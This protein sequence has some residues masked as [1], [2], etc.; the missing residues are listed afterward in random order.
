MPT[1]FKAL[2]LFS[3]VEM[4][5]KDFCNLRKSG[6]IDS[7]MAYQRPLMAHWT[8]PQT[9][10]EFI[11][12]IIK[13]WYIQPIQT[14]AEFNPDGTIKS[15]QL[16]DGKQRTNAILKIY[17]NQYQPESDSLEEMGI[18]GDYSTWSENERLQ[19]EQYPLDI[20]ILNLDNEEDVIEYFGR[21]NKGG[22]PLTTAQ[23]KRGKYI[24]TLTESNALNLAMWKEKNPTTDKL[25]LRESYSEI[26][27]IQ[28]LELERETIPN[29]ASK[30]LIDRYISNIEK[31]S[32]RMETVRVK[33]ENMQSIVNLMKTDEEFLPAYKR[34]IK[35][36]HLATLI[37]CLPAEKMEEKQLDTAESRIMSFFAQTRTERTEQRKVY[38]EGARQ[39]TATSEAIATR[40]KIMREV[41]DGKNTYNQPSKESQVTQTPAE[42][43]PATVQKKAND[44]KLMQEEHAD[45]KKK[46]EESAKL[47]NMESKLPDG[48]MLPTAVAP[49]QRNPRKN[50]KSK[51]KAPTA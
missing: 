7:S 18:K 24:K 6:G 49:K 30:G 42:E 35:K 31:D 41:L 29:F 3:R 1:K 36:T 51:V 23:A 46:E 39:A 22:I 13:G 44:L 32:A 37:S 50:G 5:I 10:D 12:S 45:L 2:K 40:L 38:D 34:V 14:I 16:V 48:E 26:I 20:L 19:F 27:T 47:D 28:L 21:V 15:I 8:K 43:T 4:T 11:D 9:L 25:F 33:L 17:D